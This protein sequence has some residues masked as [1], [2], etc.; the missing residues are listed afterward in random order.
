MSRATSSTGAAS[1]GSSAIARPASRMAVR[2]RFSSSEIAASAACAF[3]RWREASVDVGIAALLLGRHVA[4]RAECDSALV[5]RPI[6]LAGDAPI[7]HVDLAAI[8]Q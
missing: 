3:A 5:V 2:W 4:G 1:V 7:E 6:E 8:A